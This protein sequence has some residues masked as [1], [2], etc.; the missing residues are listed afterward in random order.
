MVK[1]VSFLLGDAKKQSVYDGVLKRA[2]LEEMW[3][4]AITL[5]AEPGSE[6]DP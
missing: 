1:Y 5:P 3:R 4:P 6:R 2:S